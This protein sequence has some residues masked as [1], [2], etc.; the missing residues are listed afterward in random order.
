MESTCATRAVKV[1]K[2]VRR[3]VPA[4][5]SRSSV[6]ALEE[7]P[8]GVLAN[9]GITSNW[10]EVTKDEQLRDWLAANPVPAPRAKASGP[11]FEGT[12]VFVQVTFQV[13]GQPPSA[14]SL[15]DVQ[16]VRDYADLAV[17]P[18]H[19]YASQYGPNSVGVWP[20][21][22]PFTANL[23]TDTFTLSMFETWVDQIAQI[24]RDSK[25]EQSLHRDPAQQGPAEQPAIPGAAQLLP[26][27]NGQWSA[28]LS[29]ASCSAR[30]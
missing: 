20:D 10:D 6:D 17:I 4:T 27:D 28:I 12:V 8:S 13:A 1:L 11:L 29:T 15:A 16:T 21:V 22:M 23:P 18:I 24:A 7:L 14:I 25:V 26:R 3:E 5:I 30:T 2:Y 9:L 19:R